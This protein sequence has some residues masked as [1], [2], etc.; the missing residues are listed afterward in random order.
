MGAMLESRPE[1]VHSDSETA[2][3]QVS[4]TVHLKYARWGAAGLNLRAQGTLGQEEPSRLS[5]RG[6]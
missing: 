2:S 1:R 6:S 5:A 3:M 4:D